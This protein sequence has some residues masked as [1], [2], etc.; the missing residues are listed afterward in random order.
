MKQ[1]ISLPF[2]LAPKSPLF[3]LTAWLIWAVVLWFLSSSS[4]S[5]QSFPAIPHLDKI[6]HFGYFACGATLLTGY[7]K[8]SRKT[9][10]ALPILLTTLFIGATVGAIDEY[11]QSY[12]PG[13]FGNDPWDWLA[14]CAGSLA[15]ACFTLWGWAKYKGASAAKK[16]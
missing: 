11:H 6:L 8:N 12:V 10:K 14:D 4:P 7:F 15:G 1:L 13:R 2:N 9:L 16:G 3:Y 5:T